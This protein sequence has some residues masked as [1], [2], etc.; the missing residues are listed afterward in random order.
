M[1]Q[2]AKR[3]HFQDRSCWCI[4]VKFQ[5]MTINFNK[6]RIIKRAGRCDD[7]KSYLPMCGTKKN[8]Y[9]FTITLA[10]KSFYTL[11][12]GFRALDRSCLRA[13]VG[14]NSSWWLAISCVV[15]RPN[16]KW[17]RILINAFAKRNNNQIIAAAREEKCDGHSL[18][19]CR[20]TEQN[21]C[22]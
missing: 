1:Y 22:N 6:G 4:A 12:N 20:K 2:S 7:R 21:I 15:N 13:L 10:P 19:I 5:F 3:C 9:L 14:R 8:L 11:K 17:L 18:Y 16:E